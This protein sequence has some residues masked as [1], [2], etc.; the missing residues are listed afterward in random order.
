MAIDILRQCKQC[1][2]VKNVKE[3]RQY[4]KGKG[5][6]TTCSLCEK[7][8]S[9]CKY[10][11]NKQKNSFLNVTEMQ[12]LTKIERLYMELRAIGMQ[13]PAP[14]EVDTIMSSV[15]NMLQELSFIPEELAHYLTV[16]LIGKPE[17]YEDEYD[18]LVTK[19]RPM[20]GI[21]NTTG[22]PLYNDTYRLTLQSILARFEEYE[23]NYD[24]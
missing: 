9:R 10:L 23:D 22:L 1:G 3:F 18:R 2:K 14:K 12:E 19:Y 11:R 17:Y 15:D 24:G 4:Y 16:E 8:N 13:P 7:I 6:Y 5:N 21:D 20:I